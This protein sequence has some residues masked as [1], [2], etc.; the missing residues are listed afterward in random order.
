D[1][2]LRRYGRLEFLVHRS[3]KS[4]R[5]LLGNKFH[6]PMNL[7]IR[8]EHALCSNE[9]RSARRQIKHIPLP[10]QA[11]GSVFIQNHAAVDLGS[12]LKCDPAWNISLDHAGD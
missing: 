9:T 6:H 1:I 8:N 7:I 4:R 2:L 10:E 3:I 11:I 12:D 5:A